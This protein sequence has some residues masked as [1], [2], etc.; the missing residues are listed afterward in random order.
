[1]T[2]EDGYIQSDLNV[3]GF[4]FCNFNNVVSIDLIYLKSYCNNMTYV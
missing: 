3:T 2:H 4:S 1:V